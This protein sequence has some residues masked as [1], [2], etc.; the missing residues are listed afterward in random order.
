M[1]TWDRTAPAYVDEWLP[2][3][4]PYHTSL[5]AELGL[6]PRQRVLVVNSGP[7]AFAVAAA[8]AVGEGGRVQA[9]DFSPEMIALCK[10][11]A[12]ASA[13]EVG[14]GD[15]PGPWDAIACA[16][17]NREVDL[18]GELSKWADALDSHG[19]I[20]LL[21]WGPAHP[22][23]PLALLEKTLTGRD[24]P[25]TPDRAELAARFEEN[26]LSLVRCTLVRHTVTFHSAEELARAAIGAAAWR[27]DFEAQ[28]EAKKGKLLARF[29]DAALTHNRGGI[30]APVAWEPVATLAI[31]G[32]FGAEIE[33]PHRP[34]IKLPSKGTVP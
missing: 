23:D 26:G 22:D 12:A 2:R 13:V 4:V 11:R 5:A 18:S 15:A 17:G 32:L 31:A 10:E 7:G 21:L 29:Y 27:R 34:S 3:I 19:K 6:A 28:N 20:G 9:Q 1:L 16:F 14:F 25:K 24:P 30:S 8:R 33:L